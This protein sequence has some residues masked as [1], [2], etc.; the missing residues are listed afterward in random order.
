MLMKILI[1]WAAMLVGAA[2]LERF[3]RPASPHLGA[4]V[5][6]V[7]FRIVIFSAIFGF[8]FIWS[9]RPYFAAFAGL[10]FVAVFVAIN[11]WKKW[12]VD[13]P[14]VFS[15]IAFIADIF[16]YPKLFYTTFLNAASLGAVIGLM[17]GLIVAWFYVEPPVLPETGAAGWA[18]GMAA[19]WGFCLGGV[20]LPAI[21]QRY[22]RF[23]LSLT[24][25]PE[26]EPD[27][28]RLGNLATLVTHFL[29]WRGDDRA[30]RIAAWPDTPKL[31]AKPPANA[32]DLIVIV[33]CESFY[34]LRRLGMTDIAYPALDRARKQAAAWGRLG[35]SFE[36]GYT[37]R[38]EFALL[39][40]RPI[41][42]AGF[43]RYYPYLN[44]APYRCVSVPEMVRKLGYD[45]VY[46][47]PFHRGFFFRDTALPALGFERLIMLD[48]FADAPVKGAYVSDGALADRLIAEAEA[49]DGPGFLFAATMENHGP[50]EPARFADTTTPLDV[51]KEHLKS[52]DAL[53]G[54]V[55]DHFGDWPGRV[56]LL[57]YGD[58]VPVLKEFADPFPDVLTEYV[59]LELGQ[60]RRR[61][62][63]EHA[64]RDVSDLTWDFLKLA[65][66][67]E[68]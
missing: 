31:A 55:M 29:G 36:G 3:T 53:L 54:R 59:L 51:Y 39:T 18:V 67:L 30:R 9:W 47:H 33:Q 58:H 21:R 64:D 56:V 27:I 32:A 15:D 50:W 26:I 35:S 52:G 61:K 68:K 45:T 65:D 12:F 25:H 49:L 43:D 8:F 14:L 4:T 60:K 38:T 63:P 10:V 57:F 44:A 40:G 17:I 6:A 37:L 11:R 22:E 2:A 41:A 34:D 23:A 19:V 1:A 28:A 66:L 5:L 13:E 20:F 7:C 24:P 62:P 46:M 42:A 48:D 16:R